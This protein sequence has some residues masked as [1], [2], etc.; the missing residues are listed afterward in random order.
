LGKIALVAAAFGLL[1][2]PFV[3]NHLE[4]GAFYYQPV[5]E[6]LPV[7][8]VPAWSIDPAPWDSDLDRAAP[9]TDLDAEP[10]PDA[11]VPSTPDD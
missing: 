11:T 10:P 5:P 3:L 9:D 8:P 7:D 2:L 6:D 4:H 1:S